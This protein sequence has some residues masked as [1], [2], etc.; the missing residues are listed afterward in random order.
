MDT[1]LTEGRRGG[2]GAEGA[3]LLRALP[4]APARGGG[5]GAGHVTALH[6]PKRLPERAG[7]SFP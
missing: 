3:G 5:T 2:R 1:A 4:P 7:V 6:S